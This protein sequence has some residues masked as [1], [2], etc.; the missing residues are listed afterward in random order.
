[1]KKRLLAAAAL[2]VASGLCAQVPT[3]WT[4]WPNTWILWN[5]GQVASFYSQIQN[6]GVNV[7]Q[8][9][10][11]NFVPG[12]NVTF[13]FADTP[14]NPGVTSITINASGAGGGALLSATDAVN[15]APVLGGIIAANGT[16][17]WAQVGISADVLHPA[18][19]PAWN[20]SSVLYQRYPWDTTTE[21]VINI[22]FSQT[23]S[24]A[25][26]AVA[27]SFAVSVAG[28]TAGVITAP[29]AFTTDAN[30]PNVLECSTGTTATGGFTLAKGSSLPTTGYV[31][32]G[33]E[34]VDWL[35]NIPVLSGAVA[36]F[37]QSWGIFDAAGTSAIGNG[38]FVT[39]D[40]NTD[41]HWAVESCKASTC[42]GPT[43]STTVATTGWHH[44]SIVVN[45]GAT[46]VAYYV[47]GVQLSSSPLTTNIPTTA[48]N[49]SPAAKMVA[50][51][52]STGCTTTSACY[53]DFNT[54]YF[55]KP[56]TR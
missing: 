45:A 52:G 1:M 46:S 20:G 5:G 6:N 34:V 18:Q 37:R 33:G 56:V 54:V 43:A 13:G 15:T 26:A 28:A 2:L 4:Q 21:S 38:V 41:T 39:L 8:E 32:S 29:T 35:V 22:E 11:L 10:I 25:G 17:K 9:Q 40:S 27:N 3:S 24:A 7:P 14:G 36:T 48:F 19:S 44:I 42:T 23:P 51:G 50:S 16:P 49:M 12:T 30:H 53:E 47:D 55:R 31:L